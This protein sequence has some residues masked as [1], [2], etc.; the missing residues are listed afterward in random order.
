MKTRNFSNFGGGT[1]AAVNSGTIGIQKDKIVHLDPQ[2]EILYDP[3]ENIRNGKLIDDSLD[4]LVALR[5]TIDEEQLQPIRVYPL[6]PEK[7]DPSKPAMKYGIGFGHRRTLAC[8]LTSD[9]SPLIG[10]KARKVA[11]VIDIDWLKKGKSY[12]LRCQI[13]ENTARVELN[14]VELGQALRDYQRELSEEEKRHVSQAELMEA[15]GLKEKT[16]YNLLKAS[17]FHQIAKDVCHRQL[18][19]DLDTMVT[20]DLICK[21]NEQLGRA[22]FESLKVENAPNNRS[23]IRSARILAEDEAYV[24][25]P[26]TWEWPASVERA[27]AK[28]ATVSQPP[29]AANTGN[30]PGHDLPPASSQQDGAGNSH[31]GASGPGNS[32]APIPPAGNQGGGDSELNKAPAPQTPASSEP[33]KAGQGGQSGEG[34]QQA[35]ELNGSNSERV[36]GAQPAQPP[37]APQGTQSPQDTGAGKGPIIMVEFKMGSEAATTFNGEL[38]IGHKA[39]GASNG[40]VAYLNDGREEQIEVPLRHIN[41]VSINHQ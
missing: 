4:G 23:L 1:A 9:D 22:I 31:G 14:P 34:G 8:R 35:S 15:Y 29:P 16:V 6:P 27:G 40:V 17:E 28:P 5:H 12:R 19:K 18:L 33:Q 39:K 37:A 30:G 25:D 41:L 32:P 24:F 7:L 13:R 36:P 21:A 38:L 10:G 11:A 2:T 3:V 20:F 26:A